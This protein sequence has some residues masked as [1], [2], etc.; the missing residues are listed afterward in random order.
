MLF[1]FFCR[2]S[3]L[4]FGY[5]AD[6]C[7]RAKVSRREGRLR[8]REWCSWRGDGFGRECGQVRA[9]LWWGFFSA[10]GFF[11]PC[12]VQRRRGGRPLRLGR[13]RRRQWIGCR[14]RWCLPTSAKYKTRVLE[15]Q[16]RLNSI[17]W[18]RW[19]S[20][21]R[22]MRQ[23]GSE[24]ATRPWMSDLGR[25]RWWDSRGWFTA[26]GQDDRRGAA[27]ERKRKKKKKK[28]GCPAFWTF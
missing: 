5:G 20:E 16:P 21:Q 10:W 23:T 15:A 7:K 3:V 27:A 24:L 18:L 1:F 19:N 22:K 11:S 9:T 4:V 6:S 28:K 12:A 26:T 8:T 2:P 13:A 14:G 17:G 25:R